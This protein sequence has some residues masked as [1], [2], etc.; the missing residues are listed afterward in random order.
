MLLTR[1]LISRISLAKNMSGAALERIVANNKVAEQSLE[2]LKREVII[3][4]TRTARPK[5]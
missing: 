2:A 3:Q 4:N 1:Q 5:F